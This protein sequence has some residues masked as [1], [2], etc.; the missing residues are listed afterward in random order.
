M[1]IVSDAAT[2]ARCASGVTPGAN[3]LDAPLVTVEAA[4]VGGMVAGIV[5]LVLVLVVFSVVIG[6]M[7]LS[8]LIGTPGG[9][10]VVVGKVWRGL[11]VVVVVAMLLLLW[12]GG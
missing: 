4:T 9:S 1:S 5:E 6:A 10:E 8:V 12:I 3:A 7:V 2:I 11:L